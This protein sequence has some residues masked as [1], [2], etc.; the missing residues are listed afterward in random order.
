MSL[1]GPTTTTRDNSQQNSNF[2]Q[3]QQQQQAGYSQQQN[4]QQVSGT[5][6]ITP[7]MSAALANYYGSMPGQF[8]QI[9]GPLGQMAQTPLY[10]Q[11]Q[12]ANYQ[13]DLNRQLGA[14]GQNLQSSLARSGALNSN[15]AADLQTQLGLG[16]IQQM[17]NYLAQVPLLNAQYKQGVLGQLGNTL[18]NFANWKSPTIGQTTNTSQLMN[19]LNSLLS[20]SQS[21]GSATGQ[22]QTDTSD[23]KTQQQS[24]GLL[25]SLLGGILNAGLGI[26]TG[27]LSNI[28]GGGGFFSPS[29][30]S[31]APVSDMPTM[32][33]QAEALPT[34]NSMQNSW[35]PGWYQGQQPYS[36]PA[37]GM[38]G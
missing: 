13:Q 34:M 3:N 23:T 10:G 4:Q 17:Q 18:T 29:N 38:G 33:A 35:M 14:A 37:A 11:A 21:S 20:G 26:A 28:L 32:Q 8:G 22:S 30:G 7:T 15:R 9:T 19:Q 1:G 12:Q 27:G 16:G 25:Q 6:A 36:N 24:G 31:S 5:S 2:N